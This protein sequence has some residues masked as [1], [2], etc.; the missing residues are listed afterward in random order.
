MYLNYYEKNQIENCIRKKFSNKIFLEKKIEKVLFN[1]FNNDLMWFFKK[2][3]IKKENFFWKLENK[4]FRFLKRKDG[5][6]IHYNL[7]T[8][9]LNYRDLEK[10]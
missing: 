3:H 5:G 10:D 8:S 4:N 7:K 9:D 2:K 1:F 6:S